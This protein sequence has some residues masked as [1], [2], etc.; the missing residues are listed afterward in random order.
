MGRIKRIEYEDAIYHVIS[1]TSEGKSAFRKEED[2][3]Y[4]VNL[5]D[6]SFAKHD[7]ALLSFALMKNH[8]HLLIKT[9]KANLSKIMHT[10]NSNYAHY[11]N[12]EYIRKGHLFQG[13][14]K[15][16]VITDDAHFLNVLVYVN[17]NPLKA[18]IVESSK[19]YKWCSYR[20]FRDKSNAPKSLD[21]SEIYN[22]T[23]VETSKITEFI[24]SRISIY[25][26]YEE[27]LGKKSDNN[28]KEIKKIV[29]KIE[30]TFGELQKNKELKHLAIYILTSRG[31]RL[32]SISA[33]L[34]IPY[35]TVIRIR[36]KTEKR[37]A[38]DTSLLTHLN[39][40]NNLLR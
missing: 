10:L 37:M 16:Y 28:I 31:F 32:Y 14:Y 33:A 34:N 22:L 38:T 25:D 18:G 23:G 26:K 15:S 7:A 29:S 19:E 5:L 3:R 20:Y 13:R 35:T 30:N 39:K 1:K 12:S 4:F 27:N 17:L 6:Y 11:F 21:F 9:K 36:D 8:Y 24:D 40:V 2:F